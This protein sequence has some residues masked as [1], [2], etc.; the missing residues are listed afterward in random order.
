MS[1]R[2]PILWPALATRRGPGPAERDARLAVFRDR[3]AELDS[4]LAAGTLDAERHAEARRELEDAAAV[5][6]TASEAAVPTSVGGRAVLFGVVAFVP[7]A[8]FA[9]Y[10]YLGAHDAVEAAASAPGPHDLQELVEQLGAR[11]ERSPDD[12]QGWMLLGR[13]RIVLGDLAG[14]AAAWREAQ[15]LA[16]DDPTVLANVAEAL[17]LSDPGTLDGEGGILAERA[18]EADPANPK[19]LWYAGLYAE[20]RGDADLARVRWEALLEQQ[21]PGALREAIER[22]LDALAPAG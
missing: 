8:A 1:R 16:P 10:F 4:E 5:E 9:L 21:P 17:I 22:R 19:A 7:A 14:G 15:R 11:M 3:A 18:L 2:T 6:L 12:L 13:S 20:A